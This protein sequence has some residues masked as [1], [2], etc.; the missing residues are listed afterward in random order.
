M[1]TYEYE[2]AA[3]GTFDVDQRITAPAL[4]ACPTCGARVRRLISRSTFALRGGGW[5][6][7]GY[8]SSGGAGS[9]KPSGSGG[10]AGS[11]SAG[12]ASKP[13]ASSGDSLQKA[14]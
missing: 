13:K 12:G 6:R 3:C 14:G 2:C 9:S 1:P 10:A 5:Y 7:D 11:D 4:E 8:G